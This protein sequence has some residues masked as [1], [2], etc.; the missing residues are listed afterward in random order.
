MPKMPK[1]TI[2]RQMVLGA[3]LE[4]P[5]REFYGLELMNTTGLAS[6]T[7]YPILGWLDALGWVE[8]RHEDPEVGIREKRPTR[9]YYRLTADGLKSGRA[10]MAKAHRSNRPAPWWLRRTGDAL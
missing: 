10:A 8:S 1:M 2:T 5:D 6:G 4:A 9:R 3:F 7:I